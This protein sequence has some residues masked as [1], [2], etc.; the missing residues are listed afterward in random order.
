MRRA[1]VIANIGEA[2]TRTRGRGRDRRAVHSVRIDGYGYRE[3]HRGEF[4]EDDTS[5]GVLVTILHPHTNEPVLSNYESNFKRTR[6]EIVQLNDLDVRPY[7]EVRAAED[8]AWA[9]QVADSNERQTQLR[10]EEDRLTEINAVLGNMGCGGVVDVSPL[11]GQGYTLCFNLAGAEELLL[12]IRR[13]HI[14]TYSEDEK[15]TE[16]YHTIFDIKDSAGPGNLTFGQCF[17]ALRTLETL[18]ERLGYEVPSRFDGD[19]R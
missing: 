7:K 3:N 16:A 1:E 9:Q 10:V 8:A 18:M 17:D 14:S 15:L 4:I 11:I 13:P 19:G 5:R 6:H 12:K 2:V